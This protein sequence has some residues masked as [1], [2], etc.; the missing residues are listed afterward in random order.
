MGPSG[1]SWGSRGEESVGQKPP[2]EPFWGGGGAD[3]ALPHRSSH[4]QS[5]AA[6]GAQSCRPASPAAVVPMEAIERMAALCMRDPGEEEEEEGDDEDPEG[7][8]ELMVELQEV[9]GDGGGGSESPDPPTQQRLQCRCGAAPHAAPPTPQGH[10]DP[11]RGPQH[12]PAPTDLRALLAER[13]QMYRVALGNA[14]RGGDGLR[15]RRYERGLKT[16]ESML[17][18]VQKGKAI[19][20]ADIPPPVAMGVTA[21][22]P[23]P[24]TPPP[25]QPPPSTP[26]APQPPASTPPAPHPAPTADGPHSPHP[27]MGWGEP[28]CAVP[29][30]DPPGGT[31]ALL[32]DRQRDYKM[33][34]LSA[35][36]RGDVEAAAELYRVAKSIDPLL[37]AAAQGQSVPPSRV[38]PPPEQRPAA[39][40]PPPAP[41]AP[42]QPPEGAASEPHSRPTA[43]R[44][45]GGGA[46]EQLEALQQRMEPYCRA[47]AQARSRGEERKARMHERIVKQYQDAIRA[48]RAGRAVDLSELP[49]PPAEQQL[50]FLEL[51]RSQLLRAALRSKQHNDL[52]GARL[53]L[54][55][56]RG[57]AAMM[58]A[59]R[60]GLPVDIAKVPPPPDCEEDFVLQRRGANGSSAELMERL[61]QQH[62]MC[63][64]Y[65]QQFAQL[66]NIAETIRLEQWAEQC[67]RSSQVLQLSHAPGGAPPHCRYEQRS[68]SA[69]K[70]FPELSSS[71]LLLSILKG[72]NLPA[73]PGV[74]PNDLDAFV[75]FEFPHPS[76]E[77]PQ[78]DR[79]AA[80]KN[81]DC[82]EFGER[83]KLQLNRSQRGLRRLLQ[84]RGIKFEVTHKGGLFKPD[85]VVGTAQLKL[86]ALETHCEVRE[87][88]EVLDGRRPTGGRLEVMVRIREP[89]SCPQLETRTERWL[90]VLP[91]TDTPVT[92]APAA[93]VKDGN[94]SLLSFDCER[95]ERKLQALRQAQRA[96]P[97]ALQQQHR[98]LSQRLQALRS[99]LQHCGPALRQDYAAQLERYLQHYTDTARRLGTEGH[100]EAAKEAL[101]KRNL[102]ES[103]LQ[104]FRC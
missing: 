78:K 88:L 15:A 30:P 10:K 12:P 54:R 35:K 82:P 40:P 101:Y 17:S 102:V 24:S 70:T 100:R 65:S 38:P 87:L 53:Q 97:P 84:G 76:A 46:E 3:T 6:R 85:R 57:V 81:S 90:V 77:E 31:A 58:E 91:G 34:A 94:N 104:K 22:Q 20:E 18:S 89:L 44:G 45:G 33:A 80:V 50:L 52:Q 55:R 98:E 99:Q 13:A 75:R 93:P 49:V 96:A 60:G 16:L 25:P 92:K 86:E 32:R 37:A 72:I 26:P 59:A 63:V 2:R 69:I 103:E 9:L 64:R 66:G 1:S 73:P 4:E 83:F 19:P 8:E 29:P 27:P 48:L 56:A 71:D 68:L 42:L 47:A 43:E 21:P 74:A 41:P 28:H 5:R 62:E 67:R 39:R 11:P 61:R 36:R 95:L 7:E 79:T 14:R 51:R 23:P